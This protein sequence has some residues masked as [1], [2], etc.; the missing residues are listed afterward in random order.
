[1]KRQVARVRFKITAY[2]TQATSVSGTL[3][4]TAD[5]PAAH[6]YSEGI[7]NPQI[8][9]AAVSDTYAFP[10]A[11]T[12]K[13]ILAHDFFTDYQYYMADVDGAQLKIKLNGGTIYGINLAGKEFTLNNLGKLSANG[14]YTVRL[15]LMTNPLYLFQDGTIGIYEERG[16]RTPIG[17]MI[18]ERTKDN[19]TEDQ[20]G[21]GLVVALQDTKYTN[22]DGTV[23]EMLYMAQPNSENAYDIGNGDEL[24]EAAFVYN[25][26]RGYHWTWRKE[27]SKDQ[28]IRG[29]DKGNTGF[30][31]AG[32][33][34]PGITVTGQNISK[35]FV[36]SAGQMIVAMRKL[37]IA[38]ILLKDWDNGGGMNKDVDMSTNFAKDAFQ[39]VGGSSF[40][41]LLDKWGQ[42][43]RYYS[44][45]DCGYDAGCAFMQF[46]FPEYGS[47]RQCYISYQRNYNPLFIRPF[48]HF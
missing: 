7:E 42:G 6:A 37:K 45:T 38:D 2:T 29:D 33:Y 5:Q 25:D 16:T 32:H 20:E 3:T 28:I 11:T 35:W 4:S 48:V 47:P 26:M 27:G 44:S 9:T 34:E 15:K 13:N 24:K 8:T 36:P 17:I 30:Y 18:T 41:E 10:A 22:D 39:K 31:A 23:E 12:D 43:R 21:R 40:T 46:G 14:S 1:M 19:V